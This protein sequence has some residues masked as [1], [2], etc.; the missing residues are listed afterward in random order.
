[1]AAVVTGSKTV[2]QNQSPFLTAT[3]LTSLLATAPENMTIA[4]LNQ[5]KEATMRVAGGGNPAATIASL[6][7]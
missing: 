6:L 7:P 1:M 2:T 4:Q 3:L 5:L